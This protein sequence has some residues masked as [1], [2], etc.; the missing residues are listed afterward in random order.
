LKKIKIRIQ[1]VK[2]SNERKACQNFKRDIGEIERM[3]K[4]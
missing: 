3:L 4:P 1:G 2:D